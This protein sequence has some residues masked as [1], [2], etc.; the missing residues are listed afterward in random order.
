[1][2]RVNAEAFDTEDAIRLRAAA[3]IDVDALAGRHTDVGIP[4][5][6]AMMA[7]HLVARDQVGQPLGC[8]GLVSVGDGVYEIRRLFVRSTSRRAGVGTALV[9]ELELQAAELGAPA[10]V[11]ETDQAMTSMITFLE[12]SG[13]YRIAPWGAY[14]TNPGSVCLAR[15]LSRR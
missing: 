2:I 1:M 3:R 7:V 9:R 12:R 6:D 5:V 11:Y 8:G 4:L 15:T 14:A 10:V 13:Y